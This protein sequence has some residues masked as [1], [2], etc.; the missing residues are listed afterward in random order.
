[1]LFVTFVFDMHAMIYNEAA[2]ALQKE[3]QSHFDLTQVNS[4]EEF[5]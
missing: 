3:L 2:L 1:V 5:F 4:R